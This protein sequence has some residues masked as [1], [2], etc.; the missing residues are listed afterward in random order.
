[1]ETLDYPYQRRAIVGDRHFILACPTQIDAWALPG[2][3]VIG[4]DANGV[5]QFGPP[6]TVSTAR[7][8]A[9]ARANGLGFRIEVKY[10][11][12]RRDAGDSAAA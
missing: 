12:L 6:R 10:P 5:R 7:L 4:V 9:W 11:L 8:K 2:L 1:M 3:L